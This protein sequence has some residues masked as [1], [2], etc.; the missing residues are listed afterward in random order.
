MCANEH[1]QLF[2]AFSDSWSDSQLCH[3]AM[4]QAAPVAVMLTSMVAV[5]TKVRAKQV[6]LLG[7]PLTTRVGWIDSSSSRSRR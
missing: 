2:S 7:Q 1:R 3:D 6:P 4:G 5:R